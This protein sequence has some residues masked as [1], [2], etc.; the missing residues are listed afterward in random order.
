MKLFLALGVVLLVVVKICGFKTF[1][2][3]VKFCFLS[4]IGVL[5]KAG[6]GGYTVLK[7]YFLAMGLI[8]GFF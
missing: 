3:D 4:E 7:F 6:S 2:K 5:L 1:L 8:L